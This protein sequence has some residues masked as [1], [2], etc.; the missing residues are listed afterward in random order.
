V[1]YGAEKCEWPADHRTLSGLRVCC[2]RALKSVD[3]QK[4]TRGVGAGAFGKTACTGG[5]GSW[6]IWHPAAIWR[7]GVPPPLLALLANC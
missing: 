2:E 6:H 3:K 7:R 1:C 5:F 4:H